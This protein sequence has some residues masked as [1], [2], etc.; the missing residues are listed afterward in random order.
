ML[1]AIFNSE[2]GREPAANQILD[3]SMSTA[4]F[5][6]SC[7]WMWTLAQPLQRVVHCFCWGNIPS[8]YRNLFYGYIFTYKA[9][10]GHGIMVCSCGK[11]A[12]CQGVPWI[13]AHPRSGPRRHHRNTN[14]LC[15]DM[16]KPSPLV[17][18]KCRVLPV[19]GK[20]WA[21][22]LPGFK[23]RLESRN[24]IASKH[25]VSRCPPSC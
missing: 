11:L 25:V 21:T 5:P 12:I 16:E 19:C 1:D 9:W 13:T 2:I 14:S 6:R 24:S 10:H 23:M 17:N 20:G 8:D 18:K 4:A 15:S 7:L 3:C 22:G